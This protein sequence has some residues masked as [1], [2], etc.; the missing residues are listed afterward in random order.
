M[1]ATRLKKRLSNKWTLE[2]NTGT[3]EAPTWTTVNGRT[4]L[5][6]TIDPNEVD[7]SDFDSEGW[8]DS[9]TTMRKWSLSMEGW[10]GFTGPTGT[11]VADPGQT[12]LKAAGLLVGPDA[13]VE[14]Q[15]YRTDTM[16]GY[17]GSASVNYKGAGGG[18]KD[19]E[20][21]NCDFTGSGLLSPLDLSS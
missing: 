21:F 20:P 12:A 19:A 1:T 15:V 8:E 2:V 18:V 5:E 3:T 6:L 17:S 10:D 13:Y 7:V 16:L 9:L 11:P 4:K 14:I